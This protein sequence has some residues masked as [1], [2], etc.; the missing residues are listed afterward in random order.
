M[1]P[2]FLGGRIPARDA[3][4]AHAWYLRDKLLPYERTAPFGEYRNRVM[5]IADDNMQG[6]SCDDLLLGAHRPD[7]RSS[8]QR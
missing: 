2:D 8:T 3:A 1:V 4:A 6:D 7:R 5:L